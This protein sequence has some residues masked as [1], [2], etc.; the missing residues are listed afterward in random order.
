MSQN[1]LLLNVEMVESSH[2]FPCPKM[3]QHYRLSR[4]MYFHYTIQLAGCIK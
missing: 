4:K 1:P 3:S 2:D